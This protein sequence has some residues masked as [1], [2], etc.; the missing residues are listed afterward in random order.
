M[1]E[2]FSNTFSVLSGKFLSINQFKRRIVYNQYVTFGVGWLT[3]YGMF[4]VI[5]RSI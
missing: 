1:K 5:V 3:V 4:K 2:F